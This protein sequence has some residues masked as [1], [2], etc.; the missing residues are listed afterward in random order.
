MT[1]EEATEAELP[2]ESAGSRLTRARETAGLSRAQLAGITK[3]PE[4]HLLAIEAGDFAALAAR[5]YAVGFSRSYARAVGLDEGEIVAQVRNELAK[6]EPEARRSLPAFEPGDP[7]RL[8]GRRLAW[9]AALAALLLV[10]GGFAVWGSHYLPGG[11]LPSLVPDEPSVSATSQAAAPAAASGG[12]AVVFTA[13]EPE[14]WVKFYDA[15][16]N[17]LMQKQMALGETYTVPADVPGPQLWTARPQSL[18]ITVGGQ[19]VPKLSD[20]QQTMKDVPVSAA[21]LLA[22]T[23]PAAIAAAPA[24]RE[25]VPDVQQRQRSAPRPRIQ[26]TPASQPTVVATPITAPVTEALADPAPAPVADR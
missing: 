25:A 26:Q 22:R 12:G 2:L 1:D 6:L 5:T 8:P 3:I 4:R 11:S 9:L 19:A 23:A 18:A 21:A 17:Q 20:V 14:L 10:I 16:G 13:L 15:A 24:S 7:A